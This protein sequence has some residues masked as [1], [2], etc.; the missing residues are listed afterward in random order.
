MRSTGPLTMA[1]ALMAASAPA[2]AQTWPTR[3]ATM[4]VPFS[5]GGP[6]VIANEAKQSKYVLDCFVALSGSSQ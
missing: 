3:P 6:G 5:A 2:L 1:V 4:V